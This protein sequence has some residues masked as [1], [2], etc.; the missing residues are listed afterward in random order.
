MTLAGPLA[1]Q[2]IDPTLQLPP[3]WWRH[4]SF[5]N[6]ILGDWANIAETL[7][8]LINYI[9]LTGQEASTLYEAAIADTH[10]LLSQQQN[11]SAIDAIA[12]AIEEHGD[13]APKRVEEILDKSDQEHCQP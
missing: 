8:K 6:P 10:T 7:G 1:E 9:G 5:N 4:P 11:C 3:H 2:Q 13:L 12:S